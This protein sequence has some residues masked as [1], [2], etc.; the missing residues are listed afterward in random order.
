MV[1]RLTVAIAAI[2][3]AATFLLPGPVPDRDVTK[4][5]ART[6]SP[7]PARPVTVT[8][9]ARRGAVTVSRSFLGLSVEYW[10]LPHFQSHASLFDRVFSLIHAPGDGP[11]ILRVGGDSA[12]RTF[13]APGVLSVPRWE[14]QL[15]PAWWRD[16]QAVVRRTGVHVIVDLNLV[17]GSASMAAL[18]ARATVA[19]LPKGRIAGFE[20]GN[21]PDIYSRRYWTKAISPGRPYGDLVPPNLSSLGYD[22]EFGTYASALS[23]VAPNVPLI[24]PAV[25]NP[26]RNLSW[27]ATLLAGPRNGLGIVSV[28][29]YPY[30]ACAPKSSPLYPTI[31]R[32]LSERASAGVARVVAPAARLAHRAGLPFRLT[33]LNSVTCGGTSGVSETFATALWAPDT[34]FELLRAGVNGANIHVRENASNAAFKLG[35]GGLRARPLLYGLALFARTLGPGAQLVHAYDQA[36]PSL[37]FKAW[38]V[39]LRGGLLHVLLIDK[40]GYA[41]RVD[42]RVPGTGP[43]TV[44][45][46]LAPSIRSRWGVSLDGQRIAGNGRWEG[47]RTTEAVARSGR[48]YEIVVPRFSAALVSVR[49][50]APAQP[51]GL[52]ATATLRAGVP[53][54]RGRTVREPTRRAK[55]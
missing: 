45:R 30:S 36:R 28:H 10:A 31:A 12:D 44:Q 49:M 25:A 8:I 33:E 48:G 17:T 15:T 34:L 20:I 35:A 13:W 47:R 7:P 2:A 11:V 46:L 24:G 51:R 4:A 40:G 6:P 38:A 18:W 53:T 16:L 14:Y 1:A 43:A 19:A 3:L 52:A 42:L 50:H 39:R 55:R 27:V 26:N 37:H 41:V 54:R 5:V 22:E 32:V 23:Q 21:E 9:S 29:R